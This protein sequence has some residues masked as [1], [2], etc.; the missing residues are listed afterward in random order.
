MT[1]NELRFQ[2]ALWTAARTL[3]VRIYRRPFSEILES[4][5]Y[6]GP[7]TYA[8]LSSDYIV[9][10][11]VR[12]VRHPWVMRDR[13]CFRE[14][15]LAYR[16]LERAGFAPTLHFGIDRGSL[17]RVDMQAHCWVVCNGEVIL[18]PPTA[19][20]VPILVWPDAGR[21]VRISDRLTQAKFD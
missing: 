21:A 11:I 9:K 8:G 2:T 3:P 6:R 7:L 10:S 15:L 19:E 4:S 12:R 5:R 20:M 18:N 1:F 17:N 13:R 14:G 16:F